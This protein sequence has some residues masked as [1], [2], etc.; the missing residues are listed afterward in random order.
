MK[1]DLKIGRPNPARLG[2]R[3]EGRGYVW[4]VKPNV[5]LRN[6]ANLSLRHHLTDTDTATNTNAP[7]INATRA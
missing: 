6:P 5:E 3:A 7:T 4:G 1:P 2:L